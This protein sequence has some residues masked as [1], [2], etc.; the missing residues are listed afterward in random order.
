MDLID[1]IGSEIDYRLTMASFAV[2]ELL[3]KEEAPIE[4]IDFVED[5]ELDFNEDDEYEE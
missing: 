1:D 3:G 2:D 4:E 5:E